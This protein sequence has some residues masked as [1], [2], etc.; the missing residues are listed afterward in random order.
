ML[1]YLVGFVTESRERNYN[2]IIRFFFCMHC[3]MYKIDWTD[4]ED[5]GPRPDDGYY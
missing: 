4:K 2:M 3:L 1:V 5:T